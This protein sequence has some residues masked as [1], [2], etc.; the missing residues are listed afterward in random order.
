MTKRLL[1]RLLA[2]VVYSILIQVIILQNMSVEGKNF[3][4]NLSGKFS[5]DFKPC[6]YFNVKKMSI[7]ENG[8]SV[9]DVDVPNV[10][11]GTTFMIRYS[12]IQFL[13]SQISR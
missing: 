4:S 13:Y 1:L 5:I 6:T 10:L 3:I 8:A 7:E 12:L 11:S 2:V 9:C